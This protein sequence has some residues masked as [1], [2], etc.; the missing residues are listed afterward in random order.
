[1][2]QV[3]HGKPADFL[4][5]GPEVLFR[6]F[7]LLSSSVVSNRGQLEDS[8][9]VRYPW[10]TTSP[11]STVSNLL[12]ASLAVSDLLISAFSLTGCFPPCHWP[13]DIYLSPNRW[14]YSCLFPAALCPVCGPVLHPCLWPADFSP[15]SNL[16]SALSLTNWYQSCFWPADVSPFS[17]VRKTKLMKLGNLGWILY[18][19]VSPSVN[20]VCRILV[21]YIPS[22]YM[23]VLGHL[24]LY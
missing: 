15:F 4:S 16:L 5:S 7:S 12:I 21:P 14:F 11:F 3:R 24:L 1:M 18:V 8:S 2:E 9:L 17:A 10:A 19:V 23:M 20:P 6:V 13:S 22:M